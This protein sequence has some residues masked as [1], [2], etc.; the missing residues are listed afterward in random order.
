LERSNLAPCQTWTC[1]AECLEAT[2]AAT[3]AAATA[4]IEHGDV[5]VSN[6]SCRYK[7]KFQI[8][9]T[10]QGTTIALDAI[11]SRWV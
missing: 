5:T 4:A 9:C 8:F 3:A 7:V 11:N 6:A 1:A 10:G 2:T